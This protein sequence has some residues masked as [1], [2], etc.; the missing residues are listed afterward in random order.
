MITKTQIKKIEK[1]RNVVTNCSYATVSGVFLDVQTANRIIT[2]FDN[3]SDANKDKFASMSVGEM[4][5]IAW[6]M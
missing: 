2:V 6:R 1:I 3:L 4:G 5:A